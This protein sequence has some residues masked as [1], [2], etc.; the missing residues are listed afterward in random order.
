MEFL[1]AIKTLILKLLSSRK[2]FFQL[3]SKYL[4]IYLILS[5]KSE[6]AII[7]VFGISSICDFVYFNEINFEKVKSDINVKVG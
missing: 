4:T 6:W 1:N 3:V 5:L 7:T 2:S